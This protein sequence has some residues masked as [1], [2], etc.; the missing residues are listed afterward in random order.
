MLDT[1]DSVSFIIKKNMKIGFKE[2]RKHNE[3]YWTSSKW[4]GIWEQLERYKKN[5]KCG[6]VERIFSVEVAFE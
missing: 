2:V 4:C 3:N 1:N 5:R 6:D